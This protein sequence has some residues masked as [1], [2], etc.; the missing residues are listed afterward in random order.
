MGVIL[1]QHVSTLKGH[2]HHAKHFGETLK[3]LYNAMLN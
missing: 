1:Q 3:K 2:H